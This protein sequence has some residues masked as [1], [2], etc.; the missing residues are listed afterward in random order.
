[1]LSCSFVEASPIALPTPPS[2]LGFASPN[3]NTTTL[4]IGDLDGLS[5]RFAIAYRFNA[6]LLP[7]RPVLRELERH[8][9]QLTTSPADHLFRGYCS[10]APEDTWVEFLPTGATPGLTNG[11][12]LVVVTRLGYA[13]TGPSQ[14]EQRFL[15]YDERD[16]KREAALGWGRMMQEEPGMKCSESTRPPALPNI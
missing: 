15:V 16:L 2:P 4:A 14:L 8:R 13:W 6:A 1:M 7:A 11:E 10:V 3:Q 12:A 9:T 5:R